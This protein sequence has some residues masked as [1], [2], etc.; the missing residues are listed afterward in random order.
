[1]TTPT[2]LT[3]TRLLSLMGAQMKDVACEKVRAHA[4][5]G[6][7]VARPNAGVTL[8]G[9]SGA[10]R[11]APG[12][13][14]APEAQIS[15]LQRRP[16]PAI[17][18]FGSRARADQEEHERREQRVVERGERDRDDALSAVHRVD[19][20]QH[21]D[22]D[23]DQSARQAAQRRRGTTGTSAATAARRLAAR[24]WRSRR[25]R[26]PAPSGRAASRGRGRS[27]GRRRTRRSRPLRARGRTDGDRDDQPEIGNAP[28]ETEVREHRDL[29]DDD[30]DEQRRDPAESH[31]GPEVVVLPLVVVD[32]ASSSS[33]RHGR[34]GRRPARSSSL[35]SWARPTGP[36]PGTHSSTST[37]C[38]R[39][40]VDVRADVRDAARDRPAARRRP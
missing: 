26:T 29:H 2:M 7:P 8:P 16:H 27:R 25:S 21:A 19:A 28:D 37:Y 35:S 32:R 22:A 1:M 40:E 20:D 9:R 34:G 23:E 3:R 10:V 15:L 24:R 39:A 18:S 13:S 30:D 14:Q 36:C 12:R 11:V 38:E 4:I 5:T 31:Q 33:S 6:E 17:R